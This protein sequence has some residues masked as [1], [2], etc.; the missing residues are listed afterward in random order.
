[1]RNIIGYYVVG[2]SYKNADLLTRGKFS[3]SKSQISLLLRQAKSDGLN[4]LMVISTCN[5]TEL[6]GI[7][8]DPQILIDYLCK[9]S[10]GMLAQF[11]QKGYVLSEQQA[12][13][14]VFKVGCG[15][16]SQIIGDFEIIGQ[17]KKS[18]YNS[19]KYDIVNGFSERL[20]NSVIQASKRIKTET[21]LSSGATSVSF[22]SVH[23]ILENV[24]DVKNKSIL[25]FGTG[26]IG[27]NTCENLIKH[28]QNDHITLINRSEESAKK[29]AGKFNLVV[30]SFNDL[31][32][33]IIKSDIVIV[34]TGADDITVD[35]SIIAND[36]P[37][38]ILDLSIPSNVDSHLKN[39]DNVTLVNLD[40]LSQLTNAALKKRK[41]YIPEANT[42]LNEI[43]N[44]FLKWIA[45]RKFAP[46]LK[47]LKQT[48]LN[49]QLSKKDEAQEFSQIVYKLTGK[50]ANYL[51]ENPSKAD[52]TLE[53]IQQVYQLDAE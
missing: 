1:M 41:Q 25:L 18:F 22:A 26:K 34:A 47:A 3:L 11:K 14:H 16:D 15:L 7:V 12:I 9:F 38:L 50:V 52:Q 40:E 30:K 13:N 2:L 21:K 6:Y 31:N 51:K 29:V 39:L 4:E 17:L 36:K 43:Q 5:R 37:L 46:T 45:H 28:T 24:K 35:Q 33:E 32:Q 42:I 27:R 44:D 53:L 8:E 20:V 19:K 49:G 48:L 23:Y 10:K